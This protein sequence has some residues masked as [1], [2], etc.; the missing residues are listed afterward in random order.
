MVL[1]QK[2]RRFCGWFTRG[3]AGA[4]PGQEMRAAQT[5]KSEVLTYLNLWKSSVLGAEGMKYL[6]IFLRENAP[7]CTV[8]AEPYRISNNSPGQPVSGLQTASLGQMA[9]Q[10]SDKAPLTKH[11]KFLIQTPTQL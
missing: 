4:D 10:H 3:Q 2:K 1:L 7:L 11:E 8:L 5:W 9:S 6:H